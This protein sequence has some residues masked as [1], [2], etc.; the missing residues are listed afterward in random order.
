MGGISIKKLLMFDEKFCSIDY[1]F[2]GS[3]LDEAINRVFHVSADKDLHIFNLRRYFLHL[4]EKEDH[5]L[6]H[7][8]G[9][10]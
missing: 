8:E 10:Q 1:W 5:V 2:N 6:F 4:R 7:W 3:P 9:F